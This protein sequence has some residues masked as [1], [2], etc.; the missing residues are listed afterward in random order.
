MNVDPYLFG[1]VLD[2]LVGNALRYAGAGGRVSLSSTSVDREVRV[3][4]ADTGPGIP[5]DEQKRVFDQWYQVQGAS[6]RHHGQG[7]YFC[8]LAVEAHGGT[9]HVE[10]LPGNNRFVVALPLSSPESSSQ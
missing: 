3:V 5:A 1:R 8:R 10:G 6:R 7:L 4:V 2:N 9:I